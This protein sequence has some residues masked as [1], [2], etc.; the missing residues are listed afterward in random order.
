MSQPL[1]AICPECEK[2]HRLRPEMAGK[3]FRCKGCGLPVR[4]PDE[5]TP[6]KSRR[7]PP[8]TRPAKPKSQPAARD[9]W[10]FDVA[11]AEA[12]GPVIKKRRTKSKRR[13]R[14]DDYDDEY[15]DDDDSNFLPNGRVAL[16]LGLVFLAFYIV[17]I[18]VMPIRIMMFGVMLLMGILMLTI[19]GFGIVIAAFSEDATTGLMVLFIP[20]YIYLYMYNS[21]RENWKIIMLGP[22]GMLIIAGTFPM[23]MLGAL[24]DVA[25]RAQ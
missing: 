1:I 16:I 8:R 4:A 21:Y 2:Q 11:A 9:L 7:I 12:A 24:V 10:D 23:M 25:S 13:S 3:Q 14:D 6:P 5:V 18:F 17:A 20:F 15:D 19:S 22:L